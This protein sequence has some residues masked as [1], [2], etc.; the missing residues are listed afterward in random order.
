[1]RQF[2]HRIAAAANA[3]HARRATVRSHYLRDEMK[4]HRRLREGGI[5]DEKIYEAAKAR[6]LAAHR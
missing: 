2:A 3:A 4:E 5:L 6:V 1:V